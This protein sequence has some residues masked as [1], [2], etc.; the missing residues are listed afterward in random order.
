MKQRNQTFSF[1]VLLAGLTLIFVG[2]FLFVK[3]ENRNNVFW[4]DLTVACLIFIVTSLT[5][6]G[7]FESNFD[8][9]KQL[10]GLGIRLVYIRLYSIF[11]IAIIAIGYF[12]K[13]QFNYQLFFQLFAAFILLVGY[14]FSHVSSGKVLSVQAEQDIHRKGKDEILKVLNQFEILFLKDLTKWSEEKQKINS[15]KED[16]HYLSPSNNPSATDLDSEIVNTI[17][18]ALIIAR[19]KNEGGIEIFSLLNKSMELLK[20]RKNIYSN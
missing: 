17:Q 19:N 15:L 9:E 2:F 20:L 16:V 8:F 7:F 5:E 10:G 3:Q 11:A 1:V 14:F 18:E 13:I 12:A 6:L 4:L